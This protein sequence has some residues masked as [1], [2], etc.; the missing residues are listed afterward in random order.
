MAGKIKVLFDLTDAVDGYAGIPQEARLTFAM[1][2]KLP[3]FEVHGLITRHNK[4]VFPR[5]GAGGSIIDQAI[6]LYDQLGIQGTLP[7]GLQNRI[8][9]FLAKIS[10]FIA[11]TFV[12]KIKAHEV[13]E[14]ELK[15]AI[16]RQYLGWSLPET[17]KSHLLKQKF[18]IANYDERFKNIG[19]KKTVV[20]DEK[21]DFLIN[22]GFRRITLADNKAAHT[23]YRHIDAIVLESPDTVGGWRVISACGK[24]IMSFTQQDIVLC[25]SAT[26]RERL[27][28]FNPF[29]KPEHVHVCHPPLVP[30][31]P[32]DK[33][34]FTKIAE[35]ITCGVSDLHPKGYV[36]P[37][38]PFP[39]F[40]AVSTIEPR[41]NYEAIIRS[42]VDHRQKHGSDTKLIIVGNWGWK[43]EQVRRLMTFHSAQG[44]LFHLTNISPTDLQVL[45]TN[46]RALLSFSVNEGF[47][48]APMEA[49]M[50]GCPA[51]VSDIPTH[52]EV[53]TD[54]VTYWKPGEDLPSIPERAP[55]LPDFVHQQHNVWKDIM[56]RYV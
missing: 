38:Q 4:S 19:R 48:C 34:D 8:Q 9:A 44:N 18:F 12:S 14:T 53:Y 41:K 31:Q 6:F 47:N 23:I 54:K 37:V 11:H 17:D 46:A 27:L 45:Y 13:V 7:Q 52:R 51:I 3:E 15:E 32:R 39:Y 56:L 10:N 42:W 28:K 55:A 40:M 5:F 22:F 1:I 33:G 20:T 29:L 21:Y 49:M 25:I 35:I 2:S 16:W 50:C 26:T 36:H 30:M 24:N 43:V